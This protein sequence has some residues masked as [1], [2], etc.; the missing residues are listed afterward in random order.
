MDPKKVKIRFTADDDESKSW[1]DE[2]SVLDT[3][4]ID[5]N[6]NFDGVDVA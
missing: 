5:T 4:S 1:L 3:E 2:Q 6:R